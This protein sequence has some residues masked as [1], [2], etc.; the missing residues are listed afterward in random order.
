MKEKRKIEKRDMVVAVFSH[1]GLDTN[2]TSFDPSGRDADRAI[3]GLRTIAEKYGL[4]LRFDREKQPMICA[5]ETILFDPDEAELPGDR[6]T[7]EEPLYITERGEVAIK[8]NYSARLTIEAGP[9]GDDET[10]LRIVRA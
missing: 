9:D 10:I 1:F 5:G 7:E 4:E 2:T 3:D 8:P 6:D